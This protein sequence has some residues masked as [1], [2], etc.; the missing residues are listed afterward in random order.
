[1]KRRRIG[2]ARGVLAAGLLALVLAS[3]TSPRNALGTNSSPCFR[4][5]AIAPTAV[6]HLGRFAGVRYLSA[7][8]LVKAIA[9]A[10]D[11]AKSL[12]AAVKANTEAVCAVE[13]LGPFV[14]TDLA[15]RW[16]PTRHR[17]RYAVVVLVARTDKLLVTVLFNREA[18]RFEKDF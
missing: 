7:K 10:S 4:A 8:Y 9:N 18:V 5:L 11:D 2:P 16:P 3:G 12:P 1:M 13:Y 15:K 17:G 6:H 14:A